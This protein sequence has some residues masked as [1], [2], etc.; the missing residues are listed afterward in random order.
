LHRLWATLAALAVL[1]GASGSVLA[2]DW[3]GIVPATTTREAV[4]ARYGAPSRTTTQKVEGFD[5]EAWVYEGPRAPAGIRRMT[6]EFGLKT[7]QGYRADLVRDLR[8]EPNPGAF[9]RATILT[10]WGVPAIVKSEEG[11]S[12]FFFYPEG[13]AVYFD[14]DGWTP[15]LM[16]FTPPQPPPPLPAERKP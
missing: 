8:L 7:D 9:T 4:R 15:T 14:R 11:K 13:L 3:G 5:T 16:L 12:V 10:G 2:L 1:A 6:V